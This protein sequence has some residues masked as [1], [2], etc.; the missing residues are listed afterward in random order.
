MFDIIIPRICL[1]HRQGLENR[2]CQFIVGLGIS[3]DGKVRFILK[4]L[5]MVKDKGFGRIV[6]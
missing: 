1:V 5:L 2:N 3:L 6:E 4:R